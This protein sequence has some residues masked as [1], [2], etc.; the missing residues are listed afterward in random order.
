MNLK[1]IPAVALA[2]LNREAK[3]LGKDLGTQDGFHFS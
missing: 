1:I 3:S 2:N